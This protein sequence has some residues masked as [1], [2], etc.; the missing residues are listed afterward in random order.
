MTR[1]MGLIA[2]LLGSALLLWVGFSIALELP[3]SP[4]RSPLKP[5]LLGLVFISAGIGWLSQADD[6]AELNA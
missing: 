2:V 6:E 1:F 4:Y 3:I 5:I